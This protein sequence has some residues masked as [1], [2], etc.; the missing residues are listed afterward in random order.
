ME[1][2]RIGS[3]AVFA[4]ALSSCTDMGTPIIAPVDHGNFVLYV[5]NQSM[6]VTLVDVEV[7]IDGG[8]AVSRDFQTNSGHTFVRFEYL[9]GEGTH[10]LRVRSKYVP[11]FQ[12]KE[13]TLSSTPF[14]IIAFW[15]SPG[16]PSHFDIDFFRNQPSWN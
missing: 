7:F 8:L 16:D 15:S 14:A 1:P 3:V 11:D 4:V 6:N 9:I 12:S 10:T 2:L 5:T 13:F